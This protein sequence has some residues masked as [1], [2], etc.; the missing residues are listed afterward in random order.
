MPGSPGFDG[1]DVLG[2]DGISPCS[3]APS[4]PFLPTLVSPS[5]TTFRNLPGAVD[6]GASSP[7][8]SLPAA[9]ATAAAGGGGIGDGGSGGSGGTSPRKL[10]A[11]PGAKSCLTDAVGSS[12]S[13]V[14]YGPPLNFPGINS[15]SSST[16]DSMRESMGTVY[17]DTGDDYCAVIVSAAA[18]EAGG[19]DGFATDMHQQRTATIVVSRPAASP[20]SVAVAGGGAARVP[21]P[22]LQNSVNDSSNNDANAGTEFDSKQVEAKAPKVSSSSSSFKSQRTFLRMRGGAGEGDDDGDGLSEQE[23]R[24]LRAV[25]TGLVDEAERHLQQGCNIEVRNCFGRYTGKEFIVLFPYFG[26]CVFFTLY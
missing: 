3:T 18:T 14:T 1:T 24:F 12:T 6:R 11:T 15:S 19:V 22:S 16:C 23:R 9:T 26:V 2:S 8:A 21:V 20:P 10:P 5:K 25:S 17:D 7:I 4:S 13:K